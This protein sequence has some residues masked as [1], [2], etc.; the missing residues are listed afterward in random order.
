[1]TKGEFLHGF[2]LQ[3]NYYSAVEKVTEETALSV[4]DGWDSLTR[5]QVYYWLADKLGIRLTAEQLT[6]C[7]TVGD[8][9]K[10]VNI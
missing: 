5:T 7:R 8:L 1:M 6:A 3:I 10:C 2:D 9:M 4:F